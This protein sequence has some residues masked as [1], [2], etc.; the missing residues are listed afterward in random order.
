MRVVKTE[1]YNSETGEVLSTRENYGVNN[2]TGWVVNYRAASLKIALECNSAVTF[3]VFHLLISMQE[4]YEDKGVICTRKYIQDTLKIS[5][6]S[7]YNALSWLIQ[8]D[9]LIETERVG[10]TEFL[11]NPSV[12]TIGREKDKRLRRWRAL[13]DEFNKKESYR[14][15]GYDAPIYDDSCVEKTTVIESDTGKIVLERSTAS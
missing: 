1:V 11:F 10:C 13:R 2:G 7:V 9:F 5:R 3:R 12:V 4:N 15:Y 6:K 14:R 8:N